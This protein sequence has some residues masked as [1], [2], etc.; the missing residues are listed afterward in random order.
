M[1]QAS[2]GDSRRRLGLAA[3]ASVQVEWAGTAPAPSPLLKSPEEDWLAGKGQ[4]E[5]ILAV[6]T[7]LNVKLKQ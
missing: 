7:G 1:V 5:Q 3:T 6:K 2:L 4:Q